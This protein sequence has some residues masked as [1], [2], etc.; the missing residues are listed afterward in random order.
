MEPSISL[1]IGDNVLGPHDVGC[2]VV[3][4][5][6]VGRRQERPLFSD[7]LGELTELTDTHLTIATERGPLRVPLNEVARAKRVPA[8][9]ASAAE[10]VALEIAANEAWPAPEQGRLGDWLLRAA[11]G[12]TGRGNT[13]LSVGDPGLPLDEAIEAVRGWYTARGLPP[14]I[15]APM[16]LAA[17]VNAALDALG[18]HTNPT[19]LV[20]TAPITGLFGAQRPDLPPVRLSRSPSPAW[21]DVIARRK[22]KLPDAAMHLLTAVR[23]VRFAEVYADT[24]ELLALARGTVTGDGRYFGIFQVEVVPAA[25]RRGLAQ[26]VVGGLAEWAGELGASTAL[27]QVEKRNVAAVA[28]YGRLGFTTHHHYLTRTAPDPPSPAPFP[29]IMS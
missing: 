23:E 29:L 14:K 13:A 26:H 6:V 19:T 9:R 5:R 1:P 16:P 2:R 11:G 7:A 3:V 27:L 22:G 28:L 21:I 8:R 4:R 24:G 12:W 20:Q 15:N 25:R 18:W 17:P 10:I